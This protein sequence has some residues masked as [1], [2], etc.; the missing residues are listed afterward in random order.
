MYAS[1][2]QID[3]LFDLDISSMYG[4]LTATL[5]VITLKT[6]LPLYRTS[7]TST[8]LFLSRL[9]RNPKPDIEYEIE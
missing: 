3:R 6:D 7:G 2:T 1:L 9:L 5:G 4:V 8:A